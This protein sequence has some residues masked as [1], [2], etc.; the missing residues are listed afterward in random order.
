MLTYPYD[1]QEH[2]RLDHQHHQLSRPHFRD[3]LEP[4]VDELSLQPD[5][6]SG[7]RDHGS[8]DLQM[9]SAT[10]HA[11]RAMSKVAATLAKNSS[12]MMTPCVYRTMSLEWFDPVRR[13]FR[14]KVV[15]TSVIA[16]KR[17]QRSTPLHRCYGKRCRDLPKA[18]VKSTIG[19]ITAFLY[20]A[21]R[22]QALHTTKASPTRY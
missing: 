3:E 6:N 11:T 7:I 17:I 20:S 1:P 16:A 13:K 21:H 5:G 18:H 12:M 19:S 10:Y 15:V 14:S 2:A 9:A 8:D 22:T 4:G